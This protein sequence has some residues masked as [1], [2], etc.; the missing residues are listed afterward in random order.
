MSRGIKITIALL[1]VTVLVIASFIVG[2]MSSN[3]MNML[4]NS[5][6]FLNMTSKSELGNVEDKLDSVYSLMRKMALEVP[7]EETATIGIL[8]GLLQANGDTHS[9]YLP[10]KVFE[11]YKQEM[12]GKYAGIGVSMSEQEGRVVVVEVFEGSPAEKAG[13]LPGDFFSAVGGEQKETWTSQEISNRVRGDEGTDVTI[14]MI[15]PYG[16]HEMPT[17]ENLYGKPYTVTIT[18]AIIVSPNVTSKILESDIGYIKV[19]SFNQTTSKDVAQQITKLKDE[20]A[21]SYILDL[22]NNPGGLLNE[23]AGLVSLFVKDGDVVRTVSRTQEEEVLRT[24]G[25]YLTDAKLVVLVNE[26]SASAS[27]IVAGALQDHERATIVGM[28]TFG[29]GSVQ[30]QLEVKGGGAILLTTAHYQTPKGRTI[31]KVGV[32]PDVVS[33]MDFM[34]IRDEA[35]DTQLKD[36]IKAIRD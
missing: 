2:F 27:E 4:K 5:G 7:S 15:R 17:E 36:A 11:E 1:T 31:N 26:A 3:A 24:D 35:Q 13:I 30:T 12:T 28:K 8:N 25:S 9:Q 10:P 23:A 16:G 20:G 14:T 29:K 19:G 21:K 32:V 34:K 33:E 18:R 22:R 6:D